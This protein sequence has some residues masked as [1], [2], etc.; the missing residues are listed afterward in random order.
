ME[1]DLKLYQVLINQSN[2]SIEVLDPETGNSLAVNE[3]SCTDLGYSR[4][5]LLSMKV[6]DIDSIV[7]PS[8]FPKIMEN[9]RRTGG[10]IWNGVHQRKDGTTFP[11][12]VSLKIVQLDRSYLVAVARDIT[13][14]KLAEEKLRRY[15]EELE[16]KVKERTLELED[17]RRTADAANK[18]KSEF[19]ANMSHELR[20]PLNSII[21]FSEI[22]RD[23]LTGPVSDTHKEYLKDVWESGKHL[24][25]L[26][27]D[28]LDLSKIEAGAMELEPEDFL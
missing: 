22:M 15:S 20:T 16:E 2:D 1:E 19:L 7:N 8:D 17:A 3:K 27:N 11:V 9:V 18:A 14:R 13:E 21:G 5:E 24:L 28:V 25:S 12:E 10:S 26:I 6:F 4:E 23:G